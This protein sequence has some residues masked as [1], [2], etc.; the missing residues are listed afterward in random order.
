MRFLKRENFVEK[1]GHYEGVEEREEEEEEEK[2]WGYFV[3]FR[4]KLKSV[5]SWM[6]VYRRMNLFGLNLN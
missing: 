2:I 6:W 3:K 1:S 4:K 5:M